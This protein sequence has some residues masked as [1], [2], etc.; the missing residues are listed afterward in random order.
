MK[1]ENPESLRI[2]R[3]A[4]THSNIQIR[5]QT[6]TST[7]FPCT[8]HVCRKPMRNRTQYT[9]YVLRTRHCIRMCVKMHALEYHVSN[10]IC[11]SPYTYGLYATIPTATSFSPQRIGLWNIHSNTKTKKKRNVNL[12]CRT[13]RRS[14]S[15]KIYSFSAP[16]CTGLSF[17]VRLERVRSKPCLPFARQRRTDSHV[18][19]FV[20][21]IRGI[22]RCASRFV[23]I[24]FDIFV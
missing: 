16:M 21:T 9:S 15:T 23:R 12:R 24:N 6:Q 5:A 4:F 13:V 19:L 8:L 14:N 2:K 10:R 1:R 20:G 3:N 18:F 7:Y 17:S 11:N 22:K